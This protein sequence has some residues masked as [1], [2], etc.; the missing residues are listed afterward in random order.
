MNAGYSMKIVATTALVV[1]VFRAAVAGG[2]A[3]PLDGVRPGPPLAAAFASDR[4]ILEAS[5]ER[6]EEDSARKAAGMFLLSLA[7]PGTG[8]LARGETRGYLYLAAELALLGTY[9][10]LETKGRD[11]VDEFEAFA[12][13]HWDYDGYSAWYEA[14]CVDCGDSCGNSYD[15][16]PLAPYGSGEYYEDIGKYST[17]W[18]WWSDDGVGNEN[19]E[20][21]DVRNVYWELRGISNMHLRRARYSLTAAFLNHAV[22][23]LDA[24]L[25]TRSEEKGSPPGETGTGSAGIE[26]DV[27]S[28]G[29]GLRCAIVA[30]Y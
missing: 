16:R 6:V 23:A 4:P 22:S 21:L 11:E 24:F 2:P 19:P 3:A 15:C 9:Y 17:Y 8:Q 5:R 28:S 7:V 25:S 30:R 20:Y 27:P 18:S 26:F 29:V 12:D 13:A 1:L 14:N 10:V